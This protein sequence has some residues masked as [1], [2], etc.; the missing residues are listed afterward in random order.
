MSDLLSLCYPISAMAKVIYIP[1]LGGGLIF[2]LQN[3]LVK[4]LNI[5]RNKN[6]KIVIFE[7]LWESSEIY[8]DKYN[9]LR[10]FYN[11]SGKPKVVWAISAGATLAVRLS[12]EFADDLTLHIVC[13]KIFGPEKIG[14][15]YIDIAPAFLESAKFSDKLASRLNPESCICY[16]PIN[17]ADKV[18]DSKDMKI[19]KA[20]I[21]N[22]PAFRHTSAISYALI[23]YLPYL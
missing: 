9:R 14:Q 19:P 6:S 2:T 13:G 4:I 21:V 8:N 18:I 22:L 1:G 10:D 17:N 7:S 23:R 16:V 3:T 20:R 11:A 12:S 15:H 5:F